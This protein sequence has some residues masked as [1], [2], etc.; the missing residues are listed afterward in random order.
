VIAILIILYTIDPRIKTG[1]PIIGCPD[2]L[3]L[4]KQRAQKAEV[5]FSPPFFP[6]S[7]K[8][9]V[10]RLDPPASAYTE[11]SSANPFLGKRIL[12]LSGEKDRLV[13]WSASEKFVEGLTVGDAQ[14]SV[15]RV[16]IHPD[17]KHECTEGMI[18]EM[19]SFIREVCL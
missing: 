18:N 11:V 5:P 12:V 9:L 8:A 3:A 15:K 17:V 1:I 6:E 2:Y 13:P 4:M 10:E 16:S 7:F 14:G 19:A